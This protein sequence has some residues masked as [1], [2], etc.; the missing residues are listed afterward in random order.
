MEAKNGAYIVSSVRTAV[1]KARRGTL[2]NVRPEAMGAVAVREAIR[3]VDG[4]EPSQV[5]DVLVGCAMPEGA[6][7]M[8][9]GRIIALKAG[10]PHSVTGATVN[11]FCSSGLQTIVM[12]SQAIAT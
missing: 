11:R 8:N 3:R 7:G 6:Q 4:L 9:V 2:K 5:D 12:A 1:G 10:L